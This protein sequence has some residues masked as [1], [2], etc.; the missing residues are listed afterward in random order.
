MEQNGMTHSTH[1]L[2]PFS[3]SRWL[4]VVLHVILTAALPILLILINA[5]LMMSN[6]YLRWEYNRPNFPPDPYGF[7]R[8]DRLTYAPLALAYLFN[9]A[10]IEFLAEQT[11]PDGSPLYSERA[12]SHMDDVKAV[13][14]GLIRFGLGLLAVY[15]LSAALMAASPPA[16]PVLFRAVFWG[17]LLTIALILLGLAVTASSFDWLFTQFHA[18]FFV[19]DSWI[20]PTSDTLIR[21]FPE[22]FWIDAFVL[23]FGG[24][25]LEAFILAVLTF[26]LCYHR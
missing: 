22:Q 25:L 17:S 9:D 15:T 19:G 13:T 8:E 3:L 11:F 4:E 6:A 5:R 7:T 20:F 12:L 14:Q 21:L 23:V 10:G 18:L 24:S 16:R 1:P 2:P 26:R